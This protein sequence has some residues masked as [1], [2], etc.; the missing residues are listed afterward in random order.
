MHGWLGEQDIELRV[1]R[2][3][4]GNWMLNGSAVPASTP[5][6]NLLQLRRMSIEEGEAMTCR[7]PGST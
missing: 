6:T 1:T 7:W 2:T 5:A 4:D 3:S